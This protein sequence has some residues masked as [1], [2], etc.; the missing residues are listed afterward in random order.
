VDKIDVV[1]V[2]G[3]NAG[4]CAAVAAAEHGARV[5]LLERA[6]AAK[7]GGNSFVTAGAFRFPYRGVDDVAAIV[8]D[9][10]LKTPERIAIGEYPETAF[11]HDLERLTQGEA[12]PELAQ[13]LASR[14]FST[15]AWLRSKGVDFVL[16]YDRQAF[17]VGGRYCFWGGVVVKTRGE[18]PGLVDALYRAAQRARVAVQ[19]GARATGLEWDAAARWWHVQATVDDRRRDYHVAAVVLACGGFEANPEMRGAHLGPRWK[20][21]KIRGTPYNT[22]D[23]IRL[24]LAAGGRPFGE[25]SG[26]HAVAWDLNAPDSNAARLVQHYERDSYPLGVYVNIR[27]ERFVDEGADFRTY[28]YARYGQEIMRQPHQTAFQIFDQKVVP[29][30]RRPYTLPQ[31]TRIEASTWPDL[32]KKAGIESRSLERTIAE[33]NAA[34]GNAPFNPAVRDGK[35][36][37]GITPPKS[38]WAQRLDTPPYVCFPVTCGLTFTFGGLK[39]TAEAQ[40]VDAH[41]QPIP[42]LFACGELVGGLFYHNYPGGSGLT[43]GAVFGR[44]AGAAAA[45]HAGRSG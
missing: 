21:V 43:A 26:C 31:A 35:A 29:L 20:A 4:L 39:I 23:G 12:D 45:A 28:T 42:G 11:L 6:P 5:L 2:G 1:V 14:A 24:G 13:A 15:L 40:V 3:G 17:L 34:V 18:G 25:W 22:G 7:R 16:A 36:A 38:N 44:T 9:P 10:V 19:Y 41:D 37:L 30:L 32:A 33:Y 27:G 8:S